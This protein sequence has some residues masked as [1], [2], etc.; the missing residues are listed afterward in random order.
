M[1]VW[2]R[3]TRQSGKA[4]TLRGKLWSEGAGMRRNPSH[5]DT[6][7]QSVPGSQNRESRDL[8]GGWAGLVQGTE[9]RPTGPELGSEVTGLAVSGELRPWHSTR[10]PPGKSG[11]FLRVMDCPWHLFAYSR[12][13]IEN[14]NVRVSALPAVPLA[15]FIC[16]ANLSLCVVWRQKS[17]YIG[18][19]PE[20]WNDS[21]LN[22][23]K[24]HFVLDGIEMEVTGGYQHQALNL[25]WGEEFSWSS[26]EEGSLL[27]RV[28]L[29]VSL[30]GAESPETAQSSGIA[31]VSCCKL[32]GSGWGLQP[33]KMQMTC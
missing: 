32:P 33:H 24:C 29:F 11:Q 25:I 23:I 16:L 21:S 27:L 14:S 2:W 17:A 20:F 1:K 18:F 31:A 26:S 19:S 28:F 22:E 7:G 30:L 12:L 8:E 5:K 6:G 10:G 4:W 3:M 9:K 13:K 15:S